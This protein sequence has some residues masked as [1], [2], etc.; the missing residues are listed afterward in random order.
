[1]QLAAFCGKMDF[2]SPKED[3]PEQV[4]NRA[5]EPIISSGIYSEASLPPFERAKEG[6]TANGYDTAPRIKG[7][8]VISP[9]VLVD[10]YGIKS[11]NNINAKYL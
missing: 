9:Y 1:M 5:R 10:A 4:S 6:Y 2:H 7:N 8:A 3:P 11:R